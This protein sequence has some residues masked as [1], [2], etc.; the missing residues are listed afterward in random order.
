[1]RA[2]VAL[3][4]KFRVKLV[5][6]KEIPPPELFHFTSI[7]AATSILTHK[8][9]RATGYEGLTDLEE[10]RHG[11][12]LFA[13]E[14]QRNKFSFSTRP[15]EVR[16]A[17]IRLL[18]KERDALRINCFITSFSSVESEKHWK[19]Y[20]QEGKGVCLRFKSEVFKENLLY[21]VVYDLSQKLSVVAETLNNIQ[22]L[23]DKISKTRHSCPRC[24]DQMANIILTAAVVQSAK[25]KIAS[26]DL[27]SEWRLIQWIK[28]DNSESKKGHARGR[29]YEYLDCDL[30]LTDVADNP[31]SLEAGPR[32]DPNH[33]ENLKQLLFSAKETS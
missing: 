15:N 31:I 3:V 32:S 25:F 4:D 2:C 8:Q 14:L 12:Q 11:I 33:I 18:H 6:R 7:S 5:T 24:V 20:G 9:L 27:D 23:A 22:I 16:G 13:E 19:D 1:M 21:K 30:L 10:I 29:D 28:R 26:H 17:L